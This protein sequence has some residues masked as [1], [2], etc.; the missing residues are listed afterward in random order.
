[1]RSTVGQLLAAARLRLAATPFAAPPREA[2]LLLG[3]VLGLSEAQVLARD[4][5]LTGSGCSCMVFVYLQRRWQMADPKTSASIGGGG[6]TSPRS[7]LVQLQTQLNRD[8]A[9][10]KRFLADPVAFLTEQGHELTKENQHSLN[11]MVDRLQRPGQLVPGAG[12]AP[13]D[14]SAITITIGVDF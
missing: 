8:A 7:S 11:Y 2:V 14:L 13:H 4:R 6:S 10:K 5:V 9:M 3:H 1:V 12:V